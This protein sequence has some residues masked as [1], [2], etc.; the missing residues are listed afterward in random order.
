VSQIRPLEPDD[1]GQIVAL[2]RRVFTHSAQSSDSSLESYY[3]TLLFENPWREDRFPSLVYEEPIGEIRG[4]VGAIPRPMLL[5]TERLTAVT[6]TELMVA[7]ESRG[8]VGTALFRRLFAGE[9]DITFSDRSNH[10]ARALY[11]GLGGATSVW[12][13]LY[14]TVPLDGSRPNFESA[15]TWGTTRGLAARGLRR[16]AKSLDR[17]SARF[18]RSAVDQLTTR[19]E[20]LLPETVVAN[21]RR[22]SG[23]NALIP[24]YDART[25]SW[26]LQRVG[27]GLGRV[28]TAQVTHDG[29]LVGWF[30]YV[31]RPQG[32]ADVVQLAALGNRQGMVF[33]HL[34]QHASRE[35]ARVL[36]GRMDRQFASLFGDRGVPL[37]VGHPWTAV[38]SG[39]QDVMSQFL[40][41]NA[42]FS[43]LD[44]EWWIGT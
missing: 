6:S 37:T 41:G 32:D 19:D 36:R 44:A 22:V 12:Y 13:S 14:W 7:P 38:R 40:S 20:P 11:E 8:L 30:I 29:E 43:R 34:V 4:F 2:R 17:L 28:V 23:K 26:L 24:D 5:G 39:R 21:I 25:F 27:E 1:I 18:A 3:R 31:V 9:Q 16:A 42:F 15:S 10:Q 33:D 35:G